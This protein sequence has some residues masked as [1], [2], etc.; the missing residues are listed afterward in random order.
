MR[1]R[2][3]VSP[4]LRYLVVLTVIAAFGAAGAATGRAFAQEP[5]TPGATR[6]DAG[7]A[8]ALAGTSDVC[9]STDLARHDGNPD[10][11]RRTCVATQFGELGRAEEN[12]TLLI[13]TAPEQVRVGGEFDL[14]V[15]TRNLVRDLFA[16]AAEGGYYAQPSQLTDD[17]L[18][19]GHFHTAC[20]MLPSSAAAPAPESPN[21]FFEATE[22]GAGGAVPDQVTVTVTGLPEAGEAQCM[23]WAG[24]ASH[25]VPMMARPD[26]IPAVDAVRISVVGDG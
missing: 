2:R 14:V 26:L 7:P 23:V 15:S 9:A 11:T 3:E 16:P 8:T 17:H 18:L 24:D 5:Q 13:V 19:Q 4:A 12:P 10:P 25:R 1:Q 21:A 6:S 20:R 22:D